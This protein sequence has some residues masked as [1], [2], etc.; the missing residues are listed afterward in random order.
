ML[1]RR[2]RSDKHSFDVFPEGDYDARF[3]G[4]KKRVAN[5]IEDARSEAEVNH[6]MIGVGLVSAASVTSS[7]MMVENS[8]IELENNND[9]QL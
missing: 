2:L 7:L 8:E 4:P 9:V 5:Q 1:G 3:T 6:G